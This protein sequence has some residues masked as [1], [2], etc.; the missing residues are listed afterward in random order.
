MVNDATVCEY[1]IGNVEKFR[2]VILAFIYG[3]SSLCCH[4]VH[5]NAERKRLDIKGHWQQK[6]STFY[7]KIFDL[8]SRIY[9]YSVLKVNE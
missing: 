3:R 1:A 2:Q 4:L 8:N 9:Q 6:R 5:V 7:I